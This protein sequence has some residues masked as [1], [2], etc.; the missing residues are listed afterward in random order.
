M[1]KIT[2]Q[3]VEQRQ[4]LTIFSKQ[5]RNKGKRNRENS[6]GNEIDNV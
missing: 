6:Q 1:L 4:K 5:K 3:A 2:P